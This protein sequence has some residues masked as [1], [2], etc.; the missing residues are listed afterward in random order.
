[1]T[2]APRTIHAIRIA[3][4]G[5]G[6]IGLTGAASEASPDADRASRPNLVVLLTDDQRADSVGFLGNPIVRT[7]NLDRMADEGV[8]F[9]HA[10]VTSAICTPSRASYFLG[11]YERRHG[12]NFNSGTALHPDAWADSYPVR[13][14]QAGYLVG[15]LGKN[16]VPI[17]SRG[18]DSGILEASLDAW[19]AAHGHLGFYPKARHPIFRFAE[20]D[21]QIEIL[22][23]AA[24]SFLEPEAPWLRGFVAFLEGR[25]TNQP[26]CLTIAFNLPHAAG[27]STMR[28]LPSDPA[29]YR[30]AYRDRI[31]PLPLPDTYIAK[32]DINDPKLP[33]DV[34]N[35]SNRQKSYD[36]VDTPDLLRE[37][38]VREY[39]T[40]TGIDRML[41]TIRATLSD[42]GLAEDTVIVF[43]SDHG[44]MHGEHGLG[45]KALNYEPCLRIPFVVLDPRAPESAR[46]RRLVEIALSID[47][48]PTLLDLAGATIPEAMQGRSLVPLLHRDP[49]ADAEP[50]AWRRYAFAENLWSTVF[51]NPRCESVSDAHWKYIRYYANDRTLFEDADG[52]N[53]YRVTPHQRDAY[54]R[55]L[56][57]SI[58]GEVPDHEELFH[59][60]TDPH[61][62][63]NRIDD[64]EA[65]DHLERLRKAL[66]RLV[67]EAKGDPDRP[68]LTVPLATD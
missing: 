47:I 33:S 15:Y 18:Y 8:V 66:D 46:R 1:M 36:Y 34:H 40:V 55:W 17:G 7:P 61:E 41:G 9:E 50:V 24:R 53:A 32:A 44:I 2:W 20:A 23:E 49:K 54:H 37:R 63:R 43:A 13:L 16:H 48:A 11:Q 3:I 65:A 35:A 39:Q 38:L 59:L 56:T 67:R 27:T 12:V 6:V 14:R 30:T 64:P 68:P 28:L 51:G 21:T 22:D 62:R 25:P 10:Y 60:E 57:A 31:D 42:H 52:P 4:V 58:D 26:F 45:G 5:M 19:Y 29:L